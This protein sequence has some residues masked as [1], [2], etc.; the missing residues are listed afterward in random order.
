M[1]CHL[2]VR[3]FLCPICNKGFTRKSH[4]ISHLETHLKSRVH[5]CQKC[6]I[7]FTS[8]SVFIKHLY[9]EHGMNDNELLEFLR[10]QAR[11]SML[12]TT[13]TGIEN[14]NGGEAIDENELNKDNDL[15]IASA[16]V[17]LLRSGNG[18]D[19]EDMDNERQEDDEEFDEDYQSHDSF[20]GLGENEMDDDKMG[21]LE[22]DESAVDDNQEAAAYLE[23]DLGAYQSNKNEENN[24]AGEEGAGYLDEEQYGSNDNDLGFADQVHSNQDNY[25]ERYYDSEEQQMLNEMQQDQQ[26]AAESPPSDMDALMDNAAASNTQQQAQSMQQQGNQIEIGS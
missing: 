17:A 24:E 18:E 16:A 3:P 6:S 23:N 21:D 1:K 7:Q 26:Q 15:V 9:S 2:N 13:V 25:D 12:T 20:E 10:V 11:A 8:L 5:T 19:F 22:I 14:G 4:L